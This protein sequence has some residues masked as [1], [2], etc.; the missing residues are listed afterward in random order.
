MQVTGSATSE[1]VSGRFEGGKQ[2]MN[3]ISFN[4]G[5]FHRSYSLAGAVDREGLVVRGF[6]LLLR[7][8]Y[9]FL[10]RL[11]RVTSLRLVGL[12]VQICGA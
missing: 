8:C 9:A 10:D 11:Y 3:K 2:G 1:F 6:A 7:I 12:R 5:T 4:A